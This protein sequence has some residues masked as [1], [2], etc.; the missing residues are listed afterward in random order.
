MQKIFTSWLAGILLLLFTTVSINAEDKI[1]A[2]EKLEDKVTGDM[3]KYSV[4]A[5]VDGPVYFGDIACAVK[6]RTKEFC[7]MEMVSFDSTAKVYDFNTA[8]ELEMGKALFVVDE[9]KS[10]APIVAFE[11]KSTADEY[12]AKH[13]GCTVLDFTALMEKEIK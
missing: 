5:D 2:C 13:Q 10:A 6:Y 3:M 9:K 12:A 7:A 4:S 1:S 11:S 8:T